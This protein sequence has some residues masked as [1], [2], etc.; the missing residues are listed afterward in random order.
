MISVFCIK[1]VLGDFLILGAEE[2]EMRKVSKV[3]KNFEYRL[4]SGILKKQNTSIVGR[5]SNN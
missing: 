4:K 3:S 2:I 1:V 5:F